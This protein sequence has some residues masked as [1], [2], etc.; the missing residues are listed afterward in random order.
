[1]TLKYPMQ[2][3]YKKTFTKTLKK[4]K[5]IKFFIFKEDDTFVYGIRDSM[6]QLGIQDWSRITALTYTDVMGDPTLP[7]GG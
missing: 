4:Y 5:V 3:I 2:H 1:M 7:A 6:A